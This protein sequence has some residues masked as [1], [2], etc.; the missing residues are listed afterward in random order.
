MDLPEDIETQHNFQRVDESN[1]TL[2]YEVPRLVIHV[3]QNA[4]N[5]L[6][7]YFRDYLP[8][9][10]IILD[11]MS[12]FSS[13][14]PNCSGFSLVCGLGLNEV[15]LKNNTQLTTRLIHDI[16]ANPILPFKKNW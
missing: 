2:F 3:D 4:S 6:A 15:E 16:N 1:D 12:S 8:K 5:A 7:E 11:L 14:L 10:G 13:H 9:N